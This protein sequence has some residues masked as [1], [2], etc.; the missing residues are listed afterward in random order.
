VLQGV[1]G[2]DVR[3]L[4]FRLEY[5]PPLMDRLN[6]VLA[7]LPRN[8]P[9]VWGDQWLYIWLAA[10]YLVLLYALF[11]QAM[12]NGFPDKQDGTTS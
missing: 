12:R 7:R 4:T 6:I 8:K 10:A 3:D 11:I 2:P 5:D 1:Q 9:A